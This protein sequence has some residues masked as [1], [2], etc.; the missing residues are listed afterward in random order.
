MSNFILHLN[1][2]RILNQQ[3]FFWI[4]LHYDKCKSNLT[5]EREQVQGKLPDIAIFSKFI[6]VPDLN[7]QYWIY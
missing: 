3:R 2:L 1:K 7:E 6:V 5:V 4:H